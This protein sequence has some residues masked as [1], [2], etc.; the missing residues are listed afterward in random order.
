MIEGLAIEKG[1]KLNFLFMLNSRQDGL[2]IRIYPYY[3]FE[4]TMSVKKISAEVAMQI[5]EKFPNTKIGKTNLQD[6]FVL[7][8]I[9]KKI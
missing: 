1:N 9:R 3:D 4:K 8:K 7:M 2:V 6:F 5:L